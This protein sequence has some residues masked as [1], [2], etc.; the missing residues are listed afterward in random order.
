M[1]LV[2]HA[3]DPVSRR[4]FLI[5]AEAGKAIDLLRRALTVRPKWARWLSVCRRLTLIFLVFGIEIANFLRQRN[6]SLD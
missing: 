1:I 2:H 3:V 5:E 6:D 4:R